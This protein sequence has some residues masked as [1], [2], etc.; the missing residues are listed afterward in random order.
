MKQK[1]LFFIGALS[2]LIFE[3]GCL[4]SRLSCDKISQF[5]LMSALNQ[6]LYETD[7]DYAEIKKQGDF[8]LGTFNSLDGEMVAIDGNFYQVKYDGSV[9]P[10]TDSEKCPFCVV[11]FFRAEKEVYLKEKT[12]YRQLC[13]RLDGELASKNIFYA[14]RIEGRFKFLKARSVP[15]QKKPYKNLSE[16]VKGQKVFEFRDVDAI[17]VGFKF[18]ECAQG[19]N[20]GEWH[21]HFISK[22]RKQGGH[23]LDCSITGANILIDQTNDFFLRL[24]KNKEFM[25]MNLDASRREA[26]LSAER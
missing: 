13:Q 17:L 7:F 23:L 18:P 25:K 21:F 9:S 8:G 26:S 16:A 14:V 15:K 10:V 2:V 19:I 24:P 12:D 4:S 22:D 1:S 20:T 6:G 3:V 5:S 11:K